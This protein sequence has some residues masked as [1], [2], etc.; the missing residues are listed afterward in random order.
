[1][2][3]GNENGQW[4]WS[5]M[6]LWWDKFNSS[7]QSKKVSSLNIPPPNVILNIGIFLLNHLCLIGRRKTPKGDNGAIKVETSRIW[8][9]SKE[10]KTRANGGNRGTHLFLSFLFKILKINMNISIWMLIFVTHLFPRHQCFCNIFFG[11]IFYLIVSV[12]L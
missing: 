12:H 6:L 3:V 9:T 5:L 8:G 1:M 7:Q 4:S 10:D 2:E 11:L